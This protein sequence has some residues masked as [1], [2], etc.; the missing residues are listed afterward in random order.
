MDCFLVGL[1]EDCSEE[2]LDGVLLRDFL[3]LS[4]DFEREDLLPDLRFLEFRE[5]R[6]DLEQRGEMGRRRG[7]LERGEMGRR[8]EMYRSLERSE[9]LFP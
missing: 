1:L 5:P 7:D 2:F 4:R 3:I 8:G 9:L 6:G